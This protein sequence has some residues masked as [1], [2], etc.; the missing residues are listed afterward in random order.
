MQITKGMQAVV[1]GLGAAGLSTVQ[2]LLRQGVRVAVSDRRTAEQIAPDTVRFLEQ[3]EVRLETGGHTAAFL[4][5]ADVVIPGP[6]V[7]LDSPIIGIA[8]ER[9]IPVLGE[10]ALVAGRYSVPVIAVTGSNGKTTVTSLIGALLQQAGKAPFVGG[11]IGTP[12]LA[13]FDD[14]APYQTVVL[15]LSSFQLD[16]AGDFRPDVGLL[17]NISPDHLDRHG[18][19][20]AY[21]EAKM[22]LFHSQVAGDVAILG[23]DDPLSAETRLNAGVRAFRFGRKEDCTAQISD[24]RIHVRVE[25][26]AG[27]NEAVYPLEGTRLYSSVNQLNAAAAI[28]A[29]TLCG[30]SPEAISVGLASFVPPPHRMAEVAE[31]DGVCFI[32]DSKATNIGALQAALSG[33][34]APVILIAGGRDKGSDYGLL[35]EV[36]REKVKHLI[37]IGEAAGLMHTALGS[38][39]ATESATTMADAVSKAMIAAAPGNVVLLAPGCASYDMFSGYEERGRVFADCVLEL[40][41]GWSGKRSEK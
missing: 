21:T 3:S 7:P 12:L 10:L 4:A 25:R 33:C 39:V 34:T 8:R 30:C 36:V 26:E 28:L 23:G 1:I 15:E 11:N 38:V 31:I 35:Q 41:R 17:L 20:A 13:Y 40:S 32:N 27:I 37:L 18:S 22:H 19:L 5:G 29:A 6:G 14:P 2:Y 9:G 24:G 16:L